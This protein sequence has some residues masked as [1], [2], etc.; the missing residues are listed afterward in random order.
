MW[1]TLPAV[2][3]AAAGP[4]PPL[5]LRGGGAPESE[6]LD[7][8]HTA[9][10]RLHALEHLLKTKAAEPK[11]ET[12]SPEKAAGLM[13]PVLAEPEEGDRVRVR[14]DVA[15]P[16]F[17][18]GEGVDHHS[19]GRL[20][21]FSGARCTVDFPRHGGWNGLLAELER[22]AP[23][24]DLAAVG[25]RV[26]VRR[27]VGR[28]AYGWG[29]VVRAG[30]VGSVVCL[31]HDTEAEDREICVVRF[32]GHANW[33][34]VLAE[35]EIVSPTGDR[36]KLVASRTEP[37]ASAAGARLPSG[38]LPSQHG[39]GGGYGGSYG[40]RPRLGSGAMRVG[41]VLGATAVSIS[42]STTSSNAQ[43]VRP[44]ASATHPPTYPPCY[45]PCHPPPCHPPL[46]APLTARQA[47]SSLGGRPTTR[48]ADVLRRVGGGLAVLLAFCW[49][50]G[51]SPPTAYHPLP[52][53]HYALNTTH[54]FTTH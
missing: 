39:G 33:T 49:T 28:P 37:R 17:E 25:D 46:Y 27:D 6:L 53:T 19:V 18:W 47:R 23:S 38:A 11:Q 41:W 32:E 3:L 42:A 30:A 43:E 29:P 14:G 5:V 26:R 1:L 51:A 24:R 20:T 2:L 54:Y 10:L 52:T 48:G 31:G 40:E 36:T 8:L 45:P 50:L 21:W 34:G 9:K 13:D 44:R 15:R 7:S 35:M 16:R 12:S 4:R 22:V